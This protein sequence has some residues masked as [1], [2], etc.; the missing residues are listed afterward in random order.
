MTHINSMLFKRLSH[1]CRPNRSLYVLYIFSWPDRYRFYMPN[2]LAMHV[3]I[4]GARV[5][6][7]GV[8]DGTCQ[9]RTGCA[10]VSIG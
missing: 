3:R 1:N 4:I 6:L 9:R 2:E 5:R 8:S 10:I 7:R